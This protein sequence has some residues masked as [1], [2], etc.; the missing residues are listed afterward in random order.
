MSAVR[1]TAGAPWPLLSIMLWTVR[2]DLPMEARLRSIAQAG[3]RA[4]E[5]SGEHVKWS[6][7]E[8]DRFDRARRGLGFRIDAIAGMRA[9]FA[10]PAGLDPFMADMGRAIVYASRLD[11]ARVIV[12][13]GDRLAAA[14]PGVQHHACIANL[15]KAADLAAVHGV[16]LLVQ[17]LDPE[18]APAHYLTKASKGFDIVRE[19]ASP[20]VRFLYD[21]DHEQISEGDLIE[22]LENNIAL[23]DVVHIAD[24]PGR[25]E[26]GTGEI[27]HDRNFRRLAALDYRGT[28]AMEFLPAGDPLAAWRSAAA[29]V[30]R[31]GLKPD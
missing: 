30:R 25:H 19:V 8:F 15:A 28:I 7:A 13:S 17:C 20:H 6:A 31:S 3:H 22:R 21:F 5:L 9:G 23:T 27:N 26:P 14:E 12:L 16:T 2:P 18:E 29:A 11:C 10:D 1:A 4:F 24:V